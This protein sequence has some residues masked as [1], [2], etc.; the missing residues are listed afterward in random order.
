MLRPKYLADS[1]NLLDRESQKKYWTYNCYK[2]L[3][4]LADVLAVGLIAILGQLILGNSKG[5]NPSGGLKFCLKLFRLE[6]SSYEKQLISIACLAVVLFIFKAILSLTITSK[7]FYFLAKQEVKAGEKLVKFVL[8]SSL[9]STRATSSQSYSHSLSQGLVAAV[10]R[11]LGFY[12]TLISE[13]FLLSLMMFVFIIY[14]PMSAV[15]LIAYFGMVGLFLHKLVSDQSEKLGQVVAESTTNTTR[16]IQEGLWGFREFFVSGTRHF[17]W[18]EYVLSKQNSSTLTAGVLTLASAPRHIVDTALLVGIALACAVNFLLSDSAEAARSIGFILLAGTRIAPSLLAAQGALAA[19]RQAGGESESTYQINREC[20][21]WHE[22]NQQSSNLHERTLEKP[23]NITVTNLN[24]QYPNAKTLALKDVN[25]EVQFGEFLGIVGESGSGKSTLADLLLGVLPSGGAIKIAD[26]SPEDFINSFP[27]IVGYVPQST[28]LMRTSIAENI[29]VGNRVHQIDIDRVGLCI[30]AV[31]LKEFVD[32]LPEGIFT[33]VGE[34]GDL[35]S[36]GQRQ[37]I[38][39]ARALYTSPQIIVF[40]ESTSALDAESEKAM[41]GLFSKLHGNVTII[42]IAHRINSIAFSDRV[43]VMENGTIADVG[44]F[45]KL[46]VANTTF[47]NQAKHF[48]LS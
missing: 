18:D 41:S 46:L 48:G 44:T 32:T 19:I 31:G 29:A 1:L 7:I 14:E 4:S 27:G 13:M 9:P 30:E 45:Q 11:V 34:D 26:H 17:S 38:G 37:R 16:I 23:V 22:N 47:A 35:L 5:D 42:M 12:A 15:A 40:D 10:P 39:I 8:T 21:G 24:Y 6:G 33:A 20:D 2:I 28:F 3:I 36:G 43:I 25:F